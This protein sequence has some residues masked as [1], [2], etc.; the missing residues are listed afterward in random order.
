MNWF[1]LWPWLLPGSDASHGP[2]AWH[3]ES[4]PVLR[5]ADANLGWRMHQSSELES[6]RLF[7]QA[8]DKYVAEPLYQ[9]N[10]WLNAQGGI[11]CIS[12]GCAAALGVGSCDQATLLAALARSKEILS[13]AQDALDSDFGELCR[14]HGG[15][16]RS[17]NVGLGAPSEVAT[18]ALAAAQESL[19][20][21]EADLLAGGAC[22][23]VLG[24]VLYTNL[25]LSKIGLEK[26]SVMDHQVTLEV[27]AGRGPLADVPLRHR[28]D[29][30]LHHTEILVG[31]LRTL[32]PQAL[33]SGRHE[34][35]MVEVGT[36]KAAST[37]HVL[38]TVKQARI[39][40]IDPWMEQ[41]RSKAAR[42][43][44]G[45]QAAAEAEARR[46]LEPWS[47]RV[48][49]L[50]MTADEAAK[51]LADSAFDLVFLDGGPVRELNVPIFR[52]KVRKGG[53]LCGH[54]LPH[55]P[56]YVQVILQH[57]PPGQML[58]VGPALEYARLPALAYRLLPEEQTTAARSRGRMGA[59]TMEE[60][61][62][63]MPWTEDSSEHVNFDF[64][65]SD[66]Y[67]MPQEL[68]EGPDYAFGHGEEDAER[69]HGGQVVQL[70][71]EQSVG[72]AGPIMIPDY[73]EMSE[74]E[75]YLFAQGY[76]EMMQYH[77]QNEDWAIV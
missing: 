74:M 62:W 34:L 45:I 25:E 61:A 53:I 54:D 29:L 31:L 5:A 22:T 14:R 42:G 38:K 40:T 21:L 2:G 51:V 52:P 43:A 10:S 60:Q 15:F 65:M 26:V 70:N 9:A 50:Q 66:G 73:S 30:G 48:S 24:P 46:S 35:V 58:D 12:S 77:F 1:H 44:L 11:A 19:S 20:T 32:L 68:S 8:V 75:Q 3:K 63:M 71:L 6:T 37:V 47:S 57:V 64:A 39:F 13:K 41:N 27:A 49:I 55:S 36:G 33:R 18:T 7:L 59:N 76:E 17:Q 28:V 23:A 56:D 69:A 67:Y 72:E 16:R 4:R